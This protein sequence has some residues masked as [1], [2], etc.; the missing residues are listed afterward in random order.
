MKKLSILFLGVLFVI[1]ASCVFGQ[2]ENRTRG[3]LVEKRIRVGDLLRTFYVYA[4]KTLQR[5]KKHPLV[6]VFHGGGGTAPRMGRFT[7][8]DALARKEKF[9]VVYPQGIGKNWNDGRETNKTK[10]HRENVDDISF[11]RSMIDSLTKEYRIDEKRIFSTGPSN[12][13][14]FSHYIG[15]NISDKFAAIAP[16]IGGIA[17]PFYKRF[18]PKNPVSVFII[19]GTADKLVPYNGGYIARNRGKVI[20]TDKAIELWTN[21]NKTDKKPVRGNLPDTNKRDGCTVDTFLWK[22]GK[23]RTAVKL[24]K[25]NG[26]GH[27]WA[28]GINFFPR[29]I[30]GNVC[31]DFDAAEVIW[32]FFKNH[33]KQ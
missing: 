24:Y 7:K 25:L 3:N 5:N 21:H 27:T 20:S 16:V 6:F 4:P 32:E 13:G 1:N 2:R 9:F 31:R 14:I 30:V 33:P 10:A 17:D 18:N 19:Q 12:G 29:M 11:V 8:F 23:N 26:G 22:D 28:G 15:A